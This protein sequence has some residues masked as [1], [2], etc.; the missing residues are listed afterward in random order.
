VLLAARSTN[1]PKESVANV[2]QIVA[3]DKTILT[4]RVGKLS[5]AKVESL[6]SGIDVVLGRRLQRPLD[7]EFILCANP[8]L[9]SRPAMWGTWA[10]SPPMTIAGISR[11][12]SGP[13]HNSGVRTSARPPTLRTLP[14]TPATASAT[15]RGSTPK[16]CRSRPLST[17]CTAPGNQL[18]G[19]TSLDERGDFV[20]AGFHDIL[21]GSQADG[22]VGPGDAT[23][24]NWT[25]T[26][27]H[28]MVGHSNEVG[29]GGGRTRSWNSAHLSAGCTSRRAAELGS[30]ALLDCFA[31]D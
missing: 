19:M 8:Q 10:A 9:A 21:P 1:L 24:H 13:N 3:L 5:T 18:G 7:F 25:S 22:T 26:P 2:S 14:S 4:E 20:L 23:C 28:A 30:G 12:P 6:L 17:S 31:V 15:A 16:A 11:H 29:I 27:G